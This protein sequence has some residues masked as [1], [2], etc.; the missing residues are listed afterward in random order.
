MY[1]KEKISLF[2]R[3]NFAKK[4]KIFV[5]IGEEFWMNYVIQQCMRAKKWW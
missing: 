5:I 3:E 1:L 4:L 2:Y